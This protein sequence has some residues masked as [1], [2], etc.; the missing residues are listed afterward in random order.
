NID[1]DD[2][3]EIVVAGQL[4]RDGLFIHAFNL[5]GSEVI[6][7]EYPKPMTSSGLLNNSFALADIDN[8]GLMELATIAEN[9]GVYAWDTT[10]SSSTNAPWSMKMNNNAQTRRAVNTQQF[11]NDSF[12]I[13]PAER[14]VKKNQYFTIKYSVR[15]DFEE[16]INK[17]E[18][19]YKFDVD[20]LEIISIK[21]SNNSVSEYNNLEGDFKINALKIAPGEIIS[22]TIRI[23]AKAIGETKISPDEI[24]LTIDGDS[25]S[26]SGNDIEVTVLQ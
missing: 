11:S 18:F 10:V 26:I 13:I 7:D 8:D 1:D 5:D 3:L 2:E 12:E 9:G 16:N 4:K 6:S 22:S 20:Q 19:E 25:K 24:K 14:T 23:K 17:F 21:T 15:N